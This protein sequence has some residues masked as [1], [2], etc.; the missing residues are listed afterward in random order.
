MFSLIA[1]VIAAMGL[2]SLTLL[3]INQ[4][5]KEIG[6]RKV[7]GA[8]VRAILFLLSK[9]FLKMVL[10]GNVI[11]WPLT[12]FAVQQ[13]LQNFAYRID[14]SWWVFPLAG[15]LILLMVLITVSY[16]TIKAAM[17]NPVESLRY[18]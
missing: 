18:E 10:V 1:I 7:V 3:S 11:A 13:W 6:I 14:I 8:P 16:K 5:V 17:A 12:W 4:R 15:G 9:D 2:F